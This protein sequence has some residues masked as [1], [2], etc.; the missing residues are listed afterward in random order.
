MEI[1]SARKPMYQ[2]YDIFDEKQDNAN[3]ILGVD[4]KNWK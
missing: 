1:S 4:N 3:L 2:F